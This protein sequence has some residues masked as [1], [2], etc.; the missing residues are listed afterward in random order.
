MDKTEAP[1]AMQSLKNLEEAK[2]ILNY[3]EEIKHETI[4]VCIQRPYTY[5]E[6]LHHGQVVSTGFAKCNPHDAWDE[7]LG[8]KIAVGRAVKQK[9][10]GTAKP[11]RT[12]KLN[13]NCKNILHM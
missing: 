12:L 3:N 7:E 6:V 9:E 4:R 8:V 13:M 2:K 11:A 10:R 5:A 1:V